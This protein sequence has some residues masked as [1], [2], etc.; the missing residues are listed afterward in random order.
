MRIHRRISPTHPDSQLRVADNGADPVVD[1]RPVART[2]QISKTSHL[3]V[4]ALHDGVMQ[5][6][7]HRM[8]YLQRLPARQMTGIQDFQPGLWYV[9]VFHRVAGWNSYELRNHPCSDLVKWGALDRG[10]GRA[11]KVVSSLQ[12]NRDMYAGRGAVL[13]GFIDTPASGEYEFS[14]FA[15][16]GAVVRIDG[17]VVLDAYER[18]CMTRFRGKVCLEKG[19]HRIRVDHTMTDRWALDNAL[20]LWWKTPGSETLELVPD[21]CLLHNSRHA[22]DAPRAIISVDDAA[23]DPGEAVRL[24]ATTS[25]AYA[26]QGKTPGTLK[27][28]AWDL[29]ADRSVDSTAATFTHAFTEPGKHR[30]RLTVTDPKGRT[31]SD[32]IMINVQ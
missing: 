6:R 15:M 18:G 1:G 13:S 25:F 7:A 27:T 14:A 23:P 21:D 11:I 24:S 9:P 17:E 16:M 32:E 29:D 20:R 2:F 4:G 12:R 31:G 22:A 19:L 3:R 5:P 10:Q 26:L 8:R 28:Y 30:V